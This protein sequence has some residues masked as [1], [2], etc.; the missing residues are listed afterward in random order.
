MCRRSQRRTASPMR[1][2]SA[3]TSSYAECRHAPR[4]QAHAHKQHSAHSQHTRRSR[5]QRKGRFDDVGARW[6]AMSCV[7]MLA[8][9]LLVLGIPLYEI[10][11]PRSLMAS[12]SALAGVQPSRMRA[13]PIGSAV[14]TAPRDPDRDTDS[15]LPF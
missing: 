2:P 14:R 15:P 3:C 4:A 13:A 12:T 8:C 11:R 6:R 5:L 10:V 1:R 9:R 7:G